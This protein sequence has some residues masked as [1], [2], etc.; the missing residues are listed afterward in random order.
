MSRKRTLPSLVSLR[1][2]EAAARH[3]SFRK[4]AEELSVTESA[5]SHQIA[6][7]E[8]SLDAKLF[9]RMP[10]GARLSHSGE[11]DRKSTRL[12]SSH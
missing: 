12:N 5:V 1:T 9:L 7:L 10:G 2:F 11:I 8:A 3:D 4:A 6:T